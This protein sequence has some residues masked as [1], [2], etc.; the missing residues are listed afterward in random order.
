[1]IHEYDATEAG[2]EKGEVQADNAGAEVEN[3]EV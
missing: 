3:T 1:M 2:V